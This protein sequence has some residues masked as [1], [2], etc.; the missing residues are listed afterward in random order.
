MKRLFCIAFL[1]IMLL[2][3]GCTDYADQDSSDRYSDIVQIATYTK[4]QYDSYKLQSNEII[5]SDT[6]KNYEID[7]EIA[8]I[9]ESEDYFYKSTMV[10]TNTVL[11]QKNVIFQ[12]V[13]GYI[14][15]KNEKLNTTK[16]E[17][18]R[19]PILNIPSSL[20]Y[21]GD[22]VMIEDELGEYAEWHLYYY[23]AGL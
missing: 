23:H 16:N 20:G 11:I 1:P 18:Y 4:N 22:S 17:H 3:T 9:F 6:L 7:S 19:N 14:A 12:S 21:D 10:D 13:T 2:T 15:T 5:T 8:E